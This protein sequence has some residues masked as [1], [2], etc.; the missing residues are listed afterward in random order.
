MQKPSFYDLKA[1]T[2]KG[3]D[4]LF[5]ILKG[6]KVLIVN[7]A[8]NCGLTP[9]LA[10]LQQLHEQYKERLVIIGF[11]CN[12]FNQQDK[13]NNEEISAFCSLAFGI[14]FLMM[15]KITI[16]ENTHPVYQWLTNKEQ[17]GNSNSTVW[18]NFQKYLINPDGT[19][20]DYLY[21]WRQPDS[22]KIIK[23]LESK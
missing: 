6:K 16:K 20:Y 3:E 11:P 18:W 7:T 5:S 23:W 13:G 2:I 14:D 21:P 1:S 9:Q 17:N 22:V 15:E 10:R 12:D 19:L 8:S 4:F